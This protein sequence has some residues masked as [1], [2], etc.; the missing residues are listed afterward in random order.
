MKILF[1]TD[2]F[3]P[4]VNAPATRTYEH[5]RAWIKYGAEVTVITCF[6]NFPQGKVYEG[7]KNNWK[8]TEWIDGIKVI[9]VWL[10]ISANHGFFKRIV[11][12]ISFSFTSFL[13]GLSQKCDVIIATSPQFF[14]A[15][16][17][18]TL[19]F[20][21][22]E[23]WI[24]EVRDLWPE[25]IKTVGAMNDNLFIR[26]FEKEEKWCYQSAKKIISVT[27]SFK[28]EITK[29][30]ISDEKIEVIKN[31]A[32]MELYNPLPKNQEL[33]KKLNVSDKIVLGYLGTHGMAHKLDFV[34][35]CAK[36]MQSSFPLIHFLFIGNGAEKQ[37]LQ[38][39][40]KSE[41]ITNVTMLDSVPK[42]EVSNYLSILD[43]A[44]INL[45][46]GDL[47]KTVIPSKI[48]ETAAMEIP[49]LLGVDGE[50]RSI[51]EEYGA[52]LFYEPENKK[53]FIEKTNMLFSEPSKLKEYKKGC[54]K[55]ANNY[56]R[57]KIAKNMLNVIANVV[58]NNY[59]I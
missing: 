9:R 41:K 48:F 57:K 56:D 24:M 15:L 19:S 8:K 54:R 51:I 35:D 6:P 26:Y 53:D 28:G 29:K 12:Y 49:M 59:K 45:R 14:T 36:E 13:A 4:E 47:F 27:D 32:N 44:I 11:D 31:G 3:P 7:Y 5:C 21:K 30:G 23:P 33:L 55:L 2:N 42:N 16:A 37:N 22:R 17:G 10:F 43:A 18:R 40:V 38:Q 25:S 52:G 50:A 46:K 34:L 20:W 1:L 58:K 39:K